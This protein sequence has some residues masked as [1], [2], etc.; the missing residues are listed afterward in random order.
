MDLRTEQ[1]FE[2]L[3]SLQMDALKKI[4]R[5]HAARL[6]QE[7]TAYETKLQQTKA[8]LTFVRLKR[9]E[10]TQKRASDK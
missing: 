1:E 3:E 4:E 7:V 6:E 10:A 8:D 9:V 5:E 2:Y